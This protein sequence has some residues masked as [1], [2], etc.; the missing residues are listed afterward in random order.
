VTTQE[1]EELGGLKQRM[2]ELDWDDYVRGPD[3]G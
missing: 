3:M 2:P 1:R